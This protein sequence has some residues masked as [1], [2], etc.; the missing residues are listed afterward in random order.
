MQRIVVIGG[1]WSGVAAAVRA[2]AA[3]LEVILCEKTDLLLGLGNVGGIM[4]NNGRFTAAEE[5]IALGADELFEITDRLATHR[6]VDFPGHE[7]AAF[8]DVALVEPEVRRLLKRLGVE[9]RFMTR[10]TDVR[11]EGEKRL[12]AVITADG[13]ELEADAFVE[14]TGSSGPMGNCL[15]YGNGCSMCVLRCPAFGPRV[16]ITERAGLTDIMAC[17]ADGTRGA[18]SGSCKLDKRTLSRKLRRKLEKD[19]VA[20]V[21][22]PERLI[23]REKLA[24]KVCRQYALDP[25]AENLILIDT[26]YAKLMTSYFNLE[27]LRQVEG[28]ENA[29]FIDPYAGG[30]GNSVRY[31][32]VGLRDN[33]MRA[34]GFENLFLGG[35]KSG[36][37]IGHTEAI[38]TG[39]LAGYN[40]AAQVLGGALL[41]LPESLA[42]GDL[43]AFANAALEEENALDR[44]FTFAGGE[45]FARMKE[46]GLYLTDPR[47]IRKRVEAEGLC[48]VY[49][50]PPDVIK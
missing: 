17:K 19:G 33:Y 46:R 14:T 49:K 8:Y 11:K 50:R 47:L 28:F 1:G 12:A 39:S 24:R 6:D 20:V 16:S 45:Y 30:K 5:N 9:L 10:I 7:H 25:Y 44:R 23:N 32:A 40:A 18:F 2:A 38:T 26:G 21:P 37:F 35:E 27:D 42:T 43:L 13:E 3:G 41:R 36:F 15:R 4:R 31:M 34:R 22:L 29:R 48:D